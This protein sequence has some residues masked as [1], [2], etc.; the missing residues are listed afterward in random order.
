MV[1]TM[2][3]TN[4]Q[5]KRKWWPIGLSFSHVV[6]LLSFIICHLSFSPAGA[7]SFTQRIQK[8]MKTGGRLTVTHSQDI[9]ILVNGRSNN[10]PVTTA[11][12][13]ANGK[14]NSS[15]PTRSNDIVVKNEAKPVVTPS[16]KQEEKPLPKPAAT[17]T[18]RTEPA[19]GDTAI[20]LPP[21]EPKKKVMLGSYKVTG[22]R[23]QAFA[24]GNQRKDRVKAEQT[25]ANI[26]AHFPDE[27]VYTHFYSPR[28][29][30]RV[31]N[32]RTYEEAHEMLT[33]IRKLGYTSAVIVKGK[34]TV[35]RTE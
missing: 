4:T 9:D 25:A 18:H 14:N 8:D 16:V 7:Q 33:A 2:K 12:G 17:T 24:G 13:K 22:Y 10:T 3:K 23:V 19:I 1:G 29:I 31:G 20:I 21:T 28:W 15:Q 30:C 35:Q 27:P 34:I 5:T 32:Y 11:E 26:K 6:A